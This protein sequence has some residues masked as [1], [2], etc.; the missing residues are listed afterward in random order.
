M[1]L[2]VRSNLNPAMFS[3]AMLLKNPTRAT[4]KP[5]MRARVHLRTWY[6]K[7]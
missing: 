3:T 2:L 5:T 1:R 7:I 4:T 6:W